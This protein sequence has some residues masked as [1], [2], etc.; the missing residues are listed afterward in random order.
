MAEQHYD[1][2][3]A[4]L[5]RA[6]DDGLT[7]DEVNRLKGHLKLLRDCPA[8]LS[9]RY[10]AQILLYCAR[11]SLTA[12]PKLSRAAT[13]RTTCDHVTFLLWP[14]DHPPEV[15]RML[16]RATA[17][18]VDLF[19]VLDRGDVWDVDRDD[20]FEPE[21]WRALGEFLRTASLEEGRL[22]FFDKYQFFRYRFPHSQ[23]EKGLA[24]FAE[25]YRRDPEV[26]KLTTDL[27]RIRKKAAPQERSRK[28][29]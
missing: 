13:W 14:K 2:A 29:R 27:E 15:A 26:R 20:D 6:T 8:V 23:L 21:Y 19:N 16:V 12:R 17:A 11:R 28:P 9:S 1:N 4:L 7:L 5:G 22:F 3:M 24:R 25:R 18:N 10:G